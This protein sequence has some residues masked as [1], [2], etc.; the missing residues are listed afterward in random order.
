MPEPITI[1][2][3]VD[4]TSNTDTLLPEHGWAVWIQADNSRI[5]F[6]TGQSGLLQANAQA[7][8]IDL[9]KVNAIVLSHGHY[10]HTGGLMRVLDLASQADVYLH[11]EALK[12]RYSCHPNKPSRNIGMP[13]ITRRNLQQHKSIQ[14]L[15]WTKTP[16]EVVPG[17]TATG[18]IKRLSDIEDVGGP[19]FQDAQGTRPDPI[20][21]DQAL[22]FESTQGLVVILGCAHAGVV[23]TLNH[24]ADLTGQKEFFTVMGGMHLV[25]ASPERIEHTIEALRAYSVQRIGT[26]HCTGTKVTAKLWQAFPKR[27]F[28]CSVGTHIEFQKN[29]S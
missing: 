6:D 18:P 16:T 9:A 8:G 23:N 25:S 22:F 5:L 15:T 21:D 7:L 28:S 13:D 10:D 26:A 12:P 27:C 17:I 29:V 14:N 3:L 4:N 19:F 24:I 20:L 1:T 11:P 2:I